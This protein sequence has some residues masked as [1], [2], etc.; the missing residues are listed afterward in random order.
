MA[1]L[2]AGSVVLEDGAHT[3]FCEWDAIVNLF[4]CHS[5]MRV[6]DEYPSFSN[7]VRI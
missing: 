4:D 5:S 2:K 3:P 7:I 6:K 1:S